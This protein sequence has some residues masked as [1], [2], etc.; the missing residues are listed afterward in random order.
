LKVW[1]VSTGQELFSVG[2][3]T[4]QY[5]SRPAFSPDGKR[6]ANADTDHTVKVWDVQTGQVLHNLNKGQ[7]QRVLG[8]AYSADGNRLASASEDGTVKV[9]DARTGEEL[10][11]SSIGPLPQL[12]RENIG[13]IP[14]VAFSPD[15]K[16]LATPG[17][18]QVG[19]RR[20]QE[21]EVPREVKVWDTQTGRELLT[22]KGFVGPRPALAFS[23]DGKRLA[24]S[25]GGSASFGPDVPGETKVWDTQTGQELFTL[26]AIFAGVIFSPDGRRLAG[27]GGGSRIVKVWDAQTGQELFNLKAS[28]NVSSLAFSPDGHWLVGDPGG[29]LTGWDATPRPEKP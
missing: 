13:R 21:F 5:H 3:G 23:P 10:F 22:L 1:D 19:V 2:N 17:P 4:G 12:F 7:T 6:L 16:R 25:P 24:A 28:G 20:N 11:S 9:W 15:G 26:K 27:S 29:T 14:Y 8:V 18:G